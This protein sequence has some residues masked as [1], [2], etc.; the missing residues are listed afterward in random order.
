MHNLSGLARAAAIASQPEARVSELRQESGRPIIGYLCCFAPPEIISAAGAIPYRITG[1]PGEPTAE[2]DAYLEPYGCSYVR[3]V[4]TQALKGRLDFL[5]GLV[6]SHSCDLV[7]R[8]YG[9]WTYYHPFPYSRLFNVPHQVTPWAERFFKREL[10]F[11]KESLEQFTGQAVTAEKLR[12]EI[13]L[14]NRNRALIR[15][16]Y[17]L[18]LKNPPLIKGSEMLS[19]LLAGG[20]LPAE[21]FN[22]LLN[23]AL[24]EVEARSPEGTP[25]PRILVW[26][27]LL[28]NIAFYRMIEEAGG[29]VAADDTCIGFRL[30]EKDIPATGDPDEG[31][32]EHYFVN[33]Q[34]PRTDRG[35]GTGRFDYL[36]ERAREYNVDGVISYI[37]SFCDP[38]KFDYPDLRDYLKETDFPMLLIDDNYSFTPAGTIQTRLQAFIEL[39]AR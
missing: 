15:E 26:G 14:A 21:E 3:N 7:Q 20:W 10:G 13:D 23:E 30:F 6:I 37:I 5:D 16:L 34:C 1:R 28:D 12:E 39:L 2:A 33:F 27:S 32:K 4:F 24:E 18:R 17:Q 35:P 25:R 11:F 9:I 8:L 38:H 31:L 36:L 29:E 22:T 19:L